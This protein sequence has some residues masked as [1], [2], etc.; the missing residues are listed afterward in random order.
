MHAFNSQLAG[1]CQPQLRWID[2]NKLA[3]PGARGTAENVTRW[4]LN[5][6]L[7]EIAMTDFDR[8]PRAPGNQNRLRSNRWA[9]TTWIIGGVV[10]VVLLFVIAHNSG[11]SSEMIE[12][13]AAAPD[14]TTGTEPIAPT[15]PSVQPVAPITKPAPEASPK[16]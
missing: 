2:P 1:S 14:T 13:R 9:P 4:I 16:P 7:R 5:N 11:P 15:T 8:D 3:A 10:V 12:H 6:N